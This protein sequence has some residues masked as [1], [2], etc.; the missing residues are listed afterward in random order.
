[1]KKKVALH[2]FFR[3]F[4]VISFSSTTGSREVNRLLTGF[5][6]F[7]KVQCESQLEMST[8]G[9]ILVSQSTGKV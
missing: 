7:A 6:L 2:V 8:N 9:V 5:G 4:R 3:G 1:M